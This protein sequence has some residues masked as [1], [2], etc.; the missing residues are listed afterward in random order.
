VLW[1]EGKKKKKK[2]KK[3]RE[4]EREGG[5]GRTLPSETDSKKKW[6]RGGCLVREK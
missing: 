1:P 2:K 5:G 3:E 4:R 6:G